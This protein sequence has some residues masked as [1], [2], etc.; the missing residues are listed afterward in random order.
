MKYVFGP[1]PS[2]RLGR[3]LGIDL[4]PLKTCNWNCVY[5]QL[6]RSKPLT[7]KRRCYNP[8]DEI[9]SEIDQVLDFHQAADIEW[10]TIVGSGEPTLH[11]DIGFIIREIEQRTDTPLAVITNGSLLHL[12]EVRAEL[13][14][15]DAV[16][17][18]LDAGSTELYRNI[19]RPHPEIPFH[20]LIDGLIAFRSEYNGR[21]WVEVML[22][23]SM[24]TNEEAL[25]DI[26]AALE[27]VNPDEVHINI[28][29]RPS[30]ET[31]VQPPDRD[32]IRRAV[33]ILG[34]QTN[35][36][37]PVHGI[38]DV[39]GPNDELSELVG[40]ISRHPISEDEISVI[41]GHWPPEKVN[42]ALKE[43][44]INRFAKKVV[45]NEVVFWVASGSHFPEQ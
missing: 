39:S 14:M 43:I 11:S 10:I 42:Q 35:V 36:L 4:I 24:N 9:L 18:S 19:N 27:M 15:A 20:L 34:M 25:T 37:Y 8:P 30:A 16:L 40:I 33:S 45:R 41:L 44:E 22:V 6:G 12:P 28:P 29:T 2:R 26:S 5:C 1:I 31:W 3:S 32:T 38:Y 13:G 21:L 17:P 7:N 23:D